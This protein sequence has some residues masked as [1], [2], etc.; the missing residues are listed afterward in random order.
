MRSLAAFA[1]MLLAL[2][3]ARPAAAVALR[4]VPVARGRIPWG[5]A[6]RPDARRLVTARQW[7]MRLVERDGGILQIER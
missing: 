1:P 2:L 6:F 3:A 5:L 7:H 4:L